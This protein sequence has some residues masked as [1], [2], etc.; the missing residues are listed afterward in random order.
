ML[1]ACNRKAS[2]ISRTGKIAAAP[3]SQGGHHG[4]GGP[5]HIE[6]DTINMSDKSRPGN[7]AEFRRRET[8]FQIRFHCLENLFRLRG[9]AA[10][11][12]SAEGVVSIPTPAAG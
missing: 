1:G 4:A 6:D 5:Q 8:R 2:E 3:L 7:A 9:Q 10:Q 11:P 12:Q